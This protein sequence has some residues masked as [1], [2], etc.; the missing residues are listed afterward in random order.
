MNTSELRRRAIDLEKYFEG[1]TNKTSEVSA[2]EAYEPLQNAIRR[3]KA[4]VISKPEKIPGMH[5]WNFESGIF[6]KH[7]E[8]GATF[9]R[10]ELMLGGVEI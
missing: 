8:L 7:K 1:N 3:A 2:L 4:G 5:Y 10:F 6:W 9:A